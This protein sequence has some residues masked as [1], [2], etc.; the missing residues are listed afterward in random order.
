MNALYRKSQTRMLQ[1]SL[2]FIAFLAAGTGAITAWEYF[3]GLLAMFAAAS[4]CAAIAAFVSCCKA[5]NRASDIELE[6]ITR[7][8]RR[9]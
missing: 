6:E 7:G 3:G 4:L 1:A 9:F 2:L 5:F 8:S